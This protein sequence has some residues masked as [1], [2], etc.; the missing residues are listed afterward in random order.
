MARPLG[1]GMLNGVVVVDQVMEVANPSLHKQL[2]CVQAQCVCMYIYIYIYIPVG[3]ASMIYMC[4]TDSTR[5][6]KESVKA[7]TPGLGW[8]SR[9]P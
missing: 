6:T 3:V 5:A 8:V 4:P 9:S 1:Q 7:Q 2:S